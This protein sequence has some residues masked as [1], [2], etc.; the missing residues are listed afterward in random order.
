MKNSMPTIRS[1]TNAT[2]VKLENKRVIVEDLPNGDTGLCFKRICTKEDAEIPAALNTVV[3]GVVKKTT[4]R[5]SNEAA[6][7]LCM[8]LVDR[9]KY[10]FEITEPVKYNK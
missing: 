6:F 10:R 8:A 5:L 4:I 1:Y 9:F 3:K 2:H 7:A